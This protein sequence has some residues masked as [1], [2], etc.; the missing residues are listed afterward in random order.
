[1]V[2]PSLVLPKIDPS[3]LQRTKKDL[4]SKTSALISPRGSP[5]MA[6]R[7]HL[8][9]TS[10]QPSSMR[11]ND[12][13]ENRAGVASSLRRHATRVAHFPERLHCTTATSPSGTLTSSS[14]WARLLFTRH[15]SCSMGQGSFG[16]SLHMPPTFSESGDH[17]GP[18]PG[19]LFDGGTTH[20]SRRDGSGAPFVKSDYPLF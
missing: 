20:G 4:R 13:G 9:S 19:P 15:A 6:K 12:P 17:P 7:R 2:L 8:L 14:C 1:M 3:P 10:L 16:S 5:T 18:P 11:V